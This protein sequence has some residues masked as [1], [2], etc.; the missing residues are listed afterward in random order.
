[1]DT[2]SIKMIKEH[3]CVRP[4]Q[5]PQIILIELLLPL[6]HRDAKKGKE[7]CY[8]PKVTRSS[9][10][11]HPRNHQHPH[12]ILPLYCWELWDGKKKRHKVPSPLQPMDT[13]TNPT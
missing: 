10:P 2:S 6:W 5:I 13:E 3:A 7:R 1:M 4:L 8:V 12:R 9:H 11:R